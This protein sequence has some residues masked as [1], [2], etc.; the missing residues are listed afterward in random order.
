VRVSPGT[1]SHCAAP[2]HRTLPGGDEGEA[3]RV[4]GQVCGETVCKPTQ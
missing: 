4:G 1:D 3:E 2:L